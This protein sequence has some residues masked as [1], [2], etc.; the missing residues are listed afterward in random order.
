MSVDDTSHKHQPSTFEFTK[1][2]QWADLLVTELAG[3]VILILNPTG[4]AIWFCGAAVHELLGW[5]D[6]ELV[7]MD[8]FDLVNRT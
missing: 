4:N 1:R 6:D 7:D 8:V 2:R 5:T 3:T